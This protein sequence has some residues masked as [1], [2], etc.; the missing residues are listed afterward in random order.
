MFRSLRLLLLGAFVLLGAGIAPPSHVRAQDEC[1]GDCNADGTIDEADLQQI[2]HALFAE[3]PNETCAGIGS[4]P[5]A[6]TLVSA[7]ARAGGDCVPIAPPTLP[8]ETVY[9]TYA[10]FEIAWPIGAVDDGPLD[11]ASD[12][13]PDGA[14]IDEAGIFRWTPTAEQIGAHTIPFS[15]TDRAL[16]RSSVEGNLHLRVTPLD[17]CTTPDCNPATG[18]TGTIAPISENCCAEGPLARVPEFFLECPENPVLMIGRNVNSGFGRIQNCDKLRLI[19]FTQAGVTI[20]IHFG[21]HCLT[22][23]EILNIHVRLETADKLLV[24][25]DDVIV[26]RPTSAGFDQKLNYIAPLRDAEM[27]DEGHEANLTVDID[28]PMTGLH[29]ADTIR[30]ILTHP[31]IPDLPDLF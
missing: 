10:G 27:S 3:T 31:T 18:C 23:A 15:V 26:L 4:M 19:A 14:T 21:T 17:A 30:V 6:A 7:I 8:V 1:Q 5:G 29:L 22:T 25:R 16:P 9:R 20:R 28:D 11:Y 12:A 24:D 2:V 13:L